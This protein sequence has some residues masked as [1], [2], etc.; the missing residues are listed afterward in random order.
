MTD[1]KIR[2]IGAAVVLT[3]WLV[4]TVVAWFQPPKEMSDTERRPLDQFP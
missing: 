3:V 1:K 4:L 2:T